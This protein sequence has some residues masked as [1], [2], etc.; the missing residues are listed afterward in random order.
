[1]SALHR[2]LAVGREV[3]R[4]LLPLFGALARRVT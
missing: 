2:A 4:G 1:M 3:F